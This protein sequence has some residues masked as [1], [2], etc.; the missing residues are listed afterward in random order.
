[1]SP[2]RT[3]C[4]WRTRGSCPVP[5]SASFLAAITSSVRNRTRKVLEDRRT[6]SQVHAPCGYAHWYP[7]NW[8]IRIPVSPLLSDGQLQ[9]PLVLHAR[10]DG[11]FV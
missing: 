1:M 5:C 9:P 11:Q 3:A 8:L 7:V 10:F 6:P 4:T 2:N